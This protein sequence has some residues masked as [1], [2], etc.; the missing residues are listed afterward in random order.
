MARPKVVVDEKLGKLA[1]EELIQIKDYRLVIKLQAVIA[2][3]SYSAKEI[4]EILG[5]RKRTIYRW[6]SDF[7][8][9]GI[10]GLKDKAKGH[11]R[12]KL[13]QEQA[14]QLEKWVLEGRTADGKKVLWTIKKLQNE[15]LKAFG[16]KT[17]KTPLWLTLKRMGLVLRRPRPV[18]IKTDVA[19]QSAFKKKQKK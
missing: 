17:G 9:Y 19:K 6:N 16:I 3:K 2:S 4:A 14:N 11:L 10:E 13:S 12:R 18:H 1:S 15:V 8:K 7:K 5:V